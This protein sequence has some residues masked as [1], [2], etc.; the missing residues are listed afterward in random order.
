MRSRPAPRPPPRWAGLKFFNVYGP[1]EYHKRAQRSV[2]V[3]LHAQIRELGRARLF[4]S[5]HP[6]YPDGGQLRDFVWVGDCVN[7]T[8]W[9][10]QDPAAQSGIYNVGSGVARSFL[11]VASIL[12]KELGVA[13]DVEFID[14]PANLQDKYQYYTCARMD[15]LKAA[16]FAKPLTSLED[17]LR[18]YV[19]EFLGTE[20]P[21]R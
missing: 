10:L 2:A 9:A 20:D 4:R 16:G 15:K 13:P 19:G 21:F 17:G 5:E 12:F 6:D 1:N 11:D 3:Q 7:A 8:L 14:L 18:R